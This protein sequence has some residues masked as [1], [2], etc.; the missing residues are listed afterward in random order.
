MRMP[1]MSKTTIVLLIV[2]LAVIAFFFYQRRAKSGATKTLPSGAD[3][4]LGDVT[5][6]PT[7]GGT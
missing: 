5:L 3:V 6:T 1:A 2:A 7:E 4:S